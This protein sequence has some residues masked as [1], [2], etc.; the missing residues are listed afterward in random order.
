MR[1]SMCLAAVLSVSKSMKKRELLSTVETVDGTFD[2]ELHTAAF[3][4][5]KGCDSR[6]N[7]VAVRCAQKALVRPSSDGTGWV[8]LQ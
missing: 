3:Q 1:V 4:S 2:A 8:H 5:A 6:L 7:S